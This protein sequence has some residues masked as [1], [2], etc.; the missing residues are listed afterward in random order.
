M[1]SLKQL[2][3]RDT[4]LVVPGIFDALSARIA[5]SVGFQAL[6]QTG[7][8]TAATLLGLP[9]IGF[10]GAA[11]VTE[12][13]RRIRQ[14]VTI[15]LIVDADTGYGNALN[16]HRLVRTL[17]SAGVN[18][19]FLED[20][21]WPKRCGHMAGKAVIPVTEYLEK[22]RAALD[23]RRSDDFL[24]VARTD[25][26]QAEGLQSAL[27]R[28]IAA[29][30]AGA[31]LIFVEAPQ[32]RDELTQ[33]GQAIHAPLVANMIEGGATP[34]L[35]AE[36][37]FQLG[38]RLVLYPLSVLYANTAAAL[39]VLSELVK[40]GTTQKVADRLVTFE[41]FNQL[42]DLQGYRTLEKKFRQP[43]GGDR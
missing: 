13:A 37:L 8:G 32:S 3:Q 24:I 23:G 4:P 21:Q 11:E 19:I 29:K 5:Q 12:T 25:A 17:E 9:D 35:P 18:A 2:I 43:F 1:S 38:Y 28:G 36:E 40:T 15:P 33:I 34:I 20:Q 14:A 42:I 6:F 10:I 16:V 41:Q 31:D 27:E 39:V 30:E 22:L 7:Y 26:R